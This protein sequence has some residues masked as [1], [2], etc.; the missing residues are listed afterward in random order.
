M[1]I[2]FAPVLADV[3]YISGGLIA[4][5]LVVLLIIWVLKRG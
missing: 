4:A 2:P 3:L 5:V 1:P